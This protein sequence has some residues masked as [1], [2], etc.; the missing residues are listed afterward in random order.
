MQTLAELMLQVG[1][2]VGHVQM[3]KKNGS[4]TIAKNVRNDAVPVFKEQ[5]WEEYVPQAEPFG[6]KRF[7]PPVIP[8]VPVE[9]EEVTS[10]EAIEESAPEVETN[11]RIIPESGTTKRRG[12]KS[13]K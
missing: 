12:R 9:T 11:T 3:Y 13:S 1:K 10:Q 8:V 6:A 7:E 4:K 2:R 5:G